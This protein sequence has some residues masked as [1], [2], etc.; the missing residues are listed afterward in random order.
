MAMLQS[1]LDQ[2]RARLEAALQISD[3]RDEAWVVLTNAVDPDGSVAES[4][5]NKIVMM[6]VGL[7]SDPTLAIPAAGARVA[8][9]LHLNAFVMFMANF[10]G[11]NY[12]TGLRMMSHTIAFF[13]QNPFFI[14][15]PLPDQ[16][17][18]T[19]NIALDFVNLDWMQTNDLMAMLG[20]KYLPSAL[21]RMRGLAFANDVA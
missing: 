18:G 3:P 6:L 11:S 15:D 19:G 17:A 5:R 12:A 9:P 14:P 13:H 8:P 20:L 1:T 7:Q 10:T 16:P 4:A 2:L 21:Y